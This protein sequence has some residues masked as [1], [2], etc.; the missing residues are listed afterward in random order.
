MVTL[1]LKEEEM[2]FIAK[3]KTSKNKRNYN[4]NNV[5]H[6]HQS[7]YHLKKQIKF[8]KK[9]MSRIPSKPENALTKGI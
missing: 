9:E 3:K 6:E 4:R 8:E 1:Y 7:I 5:N 2:Q